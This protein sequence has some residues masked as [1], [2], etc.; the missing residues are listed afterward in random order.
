M[1]Q[2]WAHNPAQRSWGLSGGALL[3]LSSYL[4]VNSPVDSSPVP[5]TWHMRLTLIVAQLFLNFK[6]VERANSL[7]GTGRSRA[8]VQSGAM[9]VIG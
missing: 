8:A 7:P 5:I 3:Q 9:A 1:G 2:G 6:E 4:A